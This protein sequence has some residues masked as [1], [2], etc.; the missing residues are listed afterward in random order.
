MNAAGSNV[1]YYSTIEFGNTRH[2]IR[3]SQR[4]VN[5][6]PLSAGA[7]AA[8]AQEETSSCAIPVAQALMKAKVCCSVPS[9]RARPVPGGVAVTTVQERFVLG[10]GA[11][12]SQGICRYVTN[13]VIYIEMT[14]FATVWKG[15]LSS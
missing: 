15:W 11:H 8:V 13:T 2:S 3:L 14:H 5:C 12:T 9:L 10:L 1:K 6:V 7:P 4:R